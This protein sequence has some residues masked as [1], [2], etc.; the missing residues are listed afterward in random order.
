M[1]ENKIKGICL[2]FL[3]KQQAF[4]DTVGQHWDPLMT[5]LFIRETE[6]LRLGPRAGNSALK[7]DCNERFQEPMMNLISTAVQQHATTLAICHL[8]MPD[9][10]EDLKKPG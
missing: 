1:K 10:L 9:Q 5:A 3:G 6:T 2:F 4:T 7:R 8:L